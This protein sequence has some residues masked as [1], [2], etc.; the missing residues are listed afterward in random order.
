[1]RQN[2]DMKNRHEIII[3]RYNCR[4]TTQAWAESELKP[5]ASRHCFTLEAKP[6]AKAK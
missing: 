3:K 1:M 2:P 4:H 5:M 6:T